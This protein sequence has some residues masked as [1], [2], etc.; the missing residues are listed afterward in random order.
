MTAQGLVVDC[1][2]G[3]C[4][5]KDLGQ[6]LKQIRKVIGLR[7]SLRRMYGTS[8]SWMWHKEAFSALGSLHLAPFYG[9]LTMIERCC[10]GQAERIHATRSM[11]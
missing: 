7:I 4:S 5:H 6:R 8:I 9:V 11:R 10:R 1:V 2:E 3:S